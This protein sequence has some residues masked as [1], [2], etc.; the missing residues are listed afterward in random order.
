[1]SEERF[2]WPGT[3]SVDDTHWVRNPITDPIPETGLVEE[4]SCAHML[5]EDG[6]A[7]RIAKWEHAQMTGRSHL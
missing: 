3:S 2:A 5:L 4:A 1:M 7:F 6:A